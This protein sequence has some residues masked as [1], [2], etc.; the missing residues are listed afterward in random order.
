MRSQVATVLLT[1]QSRTVGM[2]NITSADPKA[3]AEA[4]SVCEELAPLVA[5]L[6]ETESSVQTQA[7]RLA[8]LEILYEVCVLGSGAD[9]ANT[10]AARVLRDLKAIVDADHLGVFWI[11]Q[12]TPISACVEGKRL[13]V[14]SALSFGQG[15][16][17]QGWI[18]SG[19]P[20]LALHAL[21]DDNRCIAEEALKR[22]IGSAAVLP[23][24]YDEQPMGYLVAAT[25]RSGGID[26]ADVETL[27]SVVNEMSQALARMDSQAAQGIVTP[28]EFQRLIASKSGSL[29]YL[30]TLKR[31]QVLSVCG[32]HTLDSAMRQLAKRVR[33]KL[34][35]GGAVCRR[36]QGDLVVFLPD[37]SDVFARS[38]A[39]DIA[40]TASMIG[41]PSLDGRRTI[42]LAL[43]AKAA[44]LDRQSN[45]VFAATVQ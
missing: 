32:K 21:L 35:S 19:A 23:I 33:G 11:D 28:A 29:V 24:Q 2:L 13:D 26:I 15:P 6:I 45:E 40:A 41:L 1:H 22:R 30:E 27:R 4:R 5:A 34:P 18:Q 36:D 10:L 9:T 42:P 17:L 25:H 39:N 44:V 31:E 37:C 3:L 7:R 38:W 12:G 16:G 14:F 8:Q 20:E 43:R